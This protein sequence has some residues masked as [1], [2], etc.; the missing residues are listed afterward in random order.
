ML[1][2]GLNAYHGDVAA[3]VLRDG[4]LVA[5]DGRLVE[6]R[7]SAA[8]RTEEG[9]QTLVAWQPPREIDAYHTSIRGRSEV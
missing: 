6:L 4:V 8:E 1:I 5:A 9:Q 3:A 7:S 2:V